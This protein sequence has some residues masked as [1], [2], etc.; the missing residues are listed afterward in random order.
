MAADSAS[1]G[2][3]ERAVA[4]VA[5]PVVADQ[6][7]SGAVIYREPA[8]EIGMLLEEELE[9]TT[10]REPRGAAIAAPRAWDP[11]EAAGAVVVEAAAAAVGGADSPESL[12][13][14]DL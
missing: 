10:A 13:S 4:S 3:L 12:K 14:Q 7:A 1:A 5:G 8:A 9:D 6:T 11:E 2:V